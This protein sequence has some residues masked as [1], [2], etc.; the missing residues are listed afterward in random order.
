M[1]N[2]KY[3]SLNNF[4]IPVILLAIAGVVLG[5]FIDKNLPIAIGV[6]VV[7]ALF[8]MLSL[9]GYIKITDDKIYIKYSVAGARD[10]AQLKDTFAKPIVIEIKD[11][12]SIT[13]L[14]DQSAVIFITHDGETK[15]PVRDLIGRNEFFA[16]IIELQE[17]IAKRAKE[18]KNNQT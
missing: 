13:T 17:E 9:V 12:Y 5:L 15:Y 6:A 18:K 7:C 16:I 3:K 11:L 8:A 2:K 4:L 1:R 10:G 14:P